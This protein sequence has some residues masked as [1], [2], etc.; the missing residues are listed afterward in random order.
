MT[1]IGAEGEQFTIC[2]LDIPAD[3]RNRDR[4]RRRER[5]ARVG[6]GEPFRVLKSLTILI[7]RGIDMDPHLAFHHVKYKVSDNPP[8]FLTIYS[9]VSV[10]Q[11]R[12]RK[13]VV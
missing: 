12:D 8:S 5:Q 13:S 10:K 9:T 3:Q 4:H 1:N 6:T 7:T 11:R 2:R